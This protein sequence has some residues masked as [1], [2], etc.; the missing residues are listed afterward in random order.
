MPDLI[1][2]GVD[3]FEQQRRAHLAVNVTYQAAGAMFPVT[4]PATIGLSRWDSL[5]QSGTITRY[6]SRDFFIGVADLAQNP[7]K[8]DTITETVGATEKTYR[9]AAPAGSGNHWSW[10]D[11]SQKIRRIHTHLVDVD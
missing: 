4:V 3:W 9:V 5:D 10:A 8:G 6:E 11:R 7:T 1:A 2:A